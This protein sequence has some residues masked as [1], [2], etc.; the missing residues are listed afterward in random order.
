MKNFRSIVA[1]IIAT[2]LAA[3]VVSALFSLLTSYSTGNVDINTPTIKVTYLDGTSIDNNLIWH[4]DFGEEVSTFNSVA[5]YYYIDTLTIT[6]TSDTEIIVDIY[7]TVDNKDI[8][9]D[10]Y[11]DLTVLAHDTNKTF[12]GII[13]KGSSKSIDIQVKL[14]DDV[15][16]DIQ[17]TTLTNLTINFKSTEYK[18]S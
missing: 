11:L 17:G 5:D 12:S 16:N 10:N 13:S 14:K 9:L 6:N 2:I 1:G 15:S 3:V 8:D 4:D 7:L 18:N